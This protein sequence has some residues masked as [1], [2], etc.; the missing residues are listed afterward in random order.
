MRTYEQHEAHG[1]SAG[2][3]A[4]SARLLA[5][6]HWKGESMT[7]AH[8]MQIAALTSALGLSG[9]AIAQD[10]NRTT[11]TDDRSGV[12]TNEAPLSGAIVTPEDKAAGMGKGDE[13][14]RDGNGAANDDASRSKDDIGIN[15]GPSS[16]DMA[17]DPGTANDDMIS[18]PGTA[19]DHMIL[20]PRRGDTDNDVP[21]L[22]T[23]ASPGPATNRDNAPRPDL[24]EAPSTDANVRPGD[25]EPGNAGGY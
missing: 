4:V 6:P 15:P 25:R 18:S 13:H 10:M 17:I 21:R 8:W 11:V 20:S 19:N 14:G 16:D 23:P 7:P 22:G 3:A 1:D 5:Y 12:S 24:G 2:V 9:A